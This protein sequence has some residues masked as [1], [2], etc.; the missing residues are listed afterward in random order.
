MALPSNITL[1]TITGQ[2]LDFRGTA[3]NGQV[4]IYPSKVLIDALADRIIIP[5]TITKDLV[6]GSF[7]VT[8]PVTNDPD[9]NPLNFFYYF[10]EA[11]IGGETYIIQLPSSLGSTVDISALRVDPQITQY[12]QPIAYQLWPPLQLRTETLEA[13]YSTSGAVPAPGT[14]AYLYLYS[15]TYASLAALWGTYANAVR[16]S[17]AFT[18]ARLQEILDRMTRLQNYTATAED[19]RDTTNLGVV[20]KSGYGAAMA[21][22]GTY[23]KWQNEYATY[24]LMT[25]T[26]YTWTYAQIGT[27]LSQIGLALTGQDPREVSTITDN[28]L[29]IT[30]PVNG[31]DY[32]ALTLTNQTNAQVATNYGTYGGLQNSANSI[33]FTYYLRDWADRLR[34]NANRPH[35]LLMKDYRYGINI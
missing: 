17:L 22:Y 30:R 13:F 33:G 27:L 9:V 35:A 21:K 24:N 29:S 34:T 6:N 26:S 15:N 10:E 11:F 28:L 7:S 14:Y 23:T 18:P 20:T 12:I 19:L 3:I 8:V 25:G 31:S 2:Y 4:K 1:V 32:G 5:A 16:T